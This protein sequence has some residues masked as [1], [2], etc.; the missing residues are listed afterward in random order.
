M[1]VPNGVMMQ[2][3]HWY[4][5]SNGSLWNELSEKSDELATAGITSV[6]LPPAYKGSGGSNDVGYSVYDRYDL[7]EFDQ[8]GSVRT[9][10]G[11]RN[12]YVS[13]IKTAKASGIA[14][15]AD[16]VL[17]HMMGADQQEEFRA[18]PHDP[19]DRNLAIGEVEPIKT[20]THFTFPGRDGKYSDMEWHWWHFNAIDYNSYADEAFEAVYLFEGKSFDSEVDLEKGSFDYLMGCDLDVNNPEVVDALERWGEWYVD[21][22]DLDGFR[23]DAVKHVKAGFFPHWMKHVQRYSGRYLFSV[24]EYWS[25]DINALHR[26]IDL[27]DGLVSLFDAPLHFNFHKASKWGSGYDMS[28]IFQDTLVETHPELAVTLVDNH[29]SQPLQSL[30][31]PVADWFKPLAYALILLRL[32]GYPC[33]FYADYYGAQYTDVDGE[34]NEQDISLVSHQYLIDQFMAA[35]KAYAYGTQNDYFDHPNTIGRT[36]LGTEQHPGGMAVVLSNGD[37][38]SKRMD[39]GQ[40][41]RTYVDATNHVAETITTDDE[42]WAEFLCEAGS[43]S[44]WIPAER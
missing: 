11:T 38:G 7:G 40:P 34:G 13:A 18:T 9:K 15:Y 41:N 4:V 31:S 26:F 37:S 30:E 24:G 27:T 43:V 25:G 28:K 3:F 2:F 16:V 5:P 10:Y 17:N 39:I 42:G 14:V 32:E 29:D 1:F 8:K 12:E 22:I 33:V 6:W 23:F 35:R 21:L 44:V 20:W 36:R 19:V